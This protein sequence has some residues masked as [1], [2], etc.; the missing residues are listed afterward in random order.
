MKNRDLKRLNPPMEDFGGGWN[1]D[2]KKSPDNRTVLNQIK[3]DSYYIKKWIKDYE[4]FY[5][6]LMPD[7]PTAVQVMIIEDELK[8]Y[9]AFYKKFLKMI[10]ELDK[11][12]IWAD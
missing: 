9:K 7:N 4:N 11:L 6:K 5:N 2:V 10:K 1:K 8:Y 3:T 12:G